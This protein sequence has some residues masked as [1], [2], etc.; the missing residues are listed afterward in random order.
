MDG[1]NLRLSLDGHAAIKGNGVERVREPILHV[2]LEVDSAGRAGGF[3]VDA[4]SAHVA[5]SAVGEAIVA[6]GGDAGDGAHRVLALGGRHGVGWVGGVLALVGDGDGQGV[7]GCVVWSRHDVGFVKK[8]F[9]L[10]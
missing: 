2:V 3:V 4:G 8:H 1:I 7:A 6:V 10:E 9:L 5:G